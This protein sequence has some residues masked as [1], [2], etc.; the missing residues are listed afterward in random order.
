MSL[1][2]GLSSLGFSGLNLGS[3]LGLEQWDPP[4]KPKN[5]QK[6]RNSFPLEL[7]H[8][9]SALPFHF[10][11]AQPILL[12]KMNSLS[13]FQQPLV[14]FLGIGI[15]PSDGSDDDGL[16]TS[17]PPTGLPNGF[18]LCFLLAHAFPTTP[19]TSQTKPN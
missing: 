9:P 8:L 18:Q 13:P 7:L 2:L 4:Q 3:L 1:L 5:T 11:Y 19:R 16:I 6:T 17:Q 14:P 10:S 15:I 12:F